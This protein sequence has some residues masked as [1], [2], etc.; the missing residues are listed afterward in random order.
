MLA[1]VMW[2]CHHEMACPWVADGEDD[3]QLWWVAVN[4]LNKQLC[5]AKRWGVYQ[6]GAGQGV[7]SSSP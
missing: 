2:V 6:P 7:N 3:L 1:H 5:P 4:I